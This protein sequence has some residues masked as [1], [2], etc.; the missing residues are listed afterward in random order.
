MARR[1]AVR[2][3]IVENCPLCEANVMILKTSPAVGA[4]LLINPTFSVQLNV[5]NSDLGSVA[6]EV[7][8]TVNSFTGK[9]P[10]GTKVT[11]RGQVQ[12]MN[13][14]FVGLGF[15][16]IF[17]IVLVYLLMVVN[18]QSWVDPFIII[19]ALPGAISGILWMLFLTRTTFSVPALMGAIMCVGVASANSILVVTF[20]Q[21]RRHAGDDAFNAGCVSSSATA[22][23][24]PS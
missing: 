3:L 12:S 23:S 15:G 9:L 21:E 6:K 14:S 4:K 24:Q 1:P 5:Q 13:S 2:P 8:S 22:E 10:R 7:R 11:I 19:T 18:F 20:A 16:L 17:A